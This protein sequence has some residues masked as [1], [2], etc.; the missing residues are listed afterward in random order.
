MKNVIQPVDTD[1]KFLDSIE[2]ET[3]QN[4]SSCNQCGKCTAGC[5]IAS[6]LDIMPH[7][8]MRYLQWGLK[9]ELL[10]SSFIWLCAN[11][12]ACQERCPRKLSVSD[13]AD[14]LRR[15]AIKEGVTPK[16]KDVAIFH[17]NFMKIITTFGRLNEVVLTAFQN[18]FTMNFFKDIFVGLSLF[19]K[20]RL[21]LIPHIIKDK[22]IMK[23]TSGRTDK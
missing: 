14:A 23:K 9:D 20:G 10:N 7:Q 18:I 2:A 5:P 12:M 1:K 19:L 16:E 13:V 8:V 17:K 15:Q 22:N 6:F 11:C 21:N 4:I 3:R